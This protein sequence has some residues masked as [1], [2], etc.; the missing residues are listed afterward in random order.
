M[1]QKKATL[2]YSLP[3]LKNVEVFSSFPDSCMAEYNNFIIILCLHIMKSL[4]LKAE[5]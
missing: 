3:F 4:S 2:H 5:P 1:T